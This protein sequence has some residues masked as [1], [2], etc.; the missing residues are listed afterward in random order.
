MYV[1]G[2]FTICVW[3]GSLI[4]QDVHSFQRDRTVLCTRAREIEDWKFPGHYDRNWAF[5]RFY[6][7]FISGYFD[8]NRFLRISLSVASN[9]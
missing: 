8:F 6:N 3:P 2:N 4:L 9:I 1:R 7:N 5:L